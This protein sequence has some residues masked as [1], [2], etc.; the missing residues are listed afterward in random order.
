MVN[1]TVYEQAVAHRVDDKLPLEFMCEC[2]DSQC[3]EQVVLLLAQFDRQAL[4]RAI[5]AHD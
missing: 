1:E 2:G 3:S 5:V 4:P